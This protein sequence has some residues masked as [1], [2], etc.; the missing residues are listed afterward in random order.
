M[1]LIFLLL[2]P[3]AFFCIRH[4][5]VRRRERLST[6][7][8]SLGFS[9][10]AAPPQKALAPFRPFRLWRLG[11]D[12][13]IRNLMHGELD[14]FE[15]RVCDFEFIIGTISPK[16]PNQ[17]WITRTPVLLRSMETQFPR[18]QVIPKCAE[19]AAQ[20][21]SW[22]SQVDLGDAWLR[23]D[24]S[25]GDRPL[26]SAVVDGLRRFGLLNVEA[27][28]D[29]LLLYEESDS[30]LAVD[31]VRSMIDRAVELASFL[32]RPSGRSAVS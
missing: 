12:Q 8:G 16:G 14:R 19:K 28:G 11:F 4:L 21:E 20:E 30:A 23:T 5:R 22:S 18:F 7:A 10:Q 32:T 2:L 24:A 13:A 17:L 1:V 26:P 15:L 3:L 25:S 9:F 31:D 29:S 6:L 27:N